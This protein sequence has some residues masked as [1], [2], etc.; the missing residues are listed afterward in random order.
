MP[1]RGGSQDEVCNCN[2]E[3]KVKP[4]SVVLTVATVKVLRGKLHDEIRSRSCIDGG[5][6]KKITEVEGSKKRTKGNQCLHILV[7]GGGS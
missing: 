5:V 7:I 4:V 2:Q 6:T 3:L 1:G